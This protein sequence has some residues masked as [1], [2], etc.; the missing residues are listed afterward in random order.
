ML[1]HS[2]VL[3]FCF[4]FFQRVG[5]TLSH[6]LM[7][8]VIFSLWP[9]LQILAGSIPTFGDSK[10]PVRPLGQ[11]ESAKLHSTSEPSET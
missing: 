2:L 1:L 10:F 6:V 11:Q 5:D 9:S 3:H 8:V 4:F 7:D